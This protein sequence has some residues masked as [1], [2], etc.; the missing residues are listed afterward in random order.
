MEEQDA[1]HGEV[2]AVQKSIVLNLKEICNY[3]KVQLET[4]RMKTFWLLMTKEW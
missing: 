2:E 4:E 1:P 3:G